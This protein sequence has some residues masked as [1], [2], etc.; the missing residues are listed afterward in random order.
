VLAIAARFIAIAAVVA[1]LAVPASARSVPNMANG[2]GFTFVSKKVVQGEDGH[3]SVR[4]RPSGSTC[5]LNVRYQG[6]TKQP[7]IGAAV[8][9]GGRA[10]WTWKVPSNVQAGPATA[11]VRCSRAGA[12]S[13]ALMIV[14]RLV[15]PKITV[16]KQ[17]FTTRPNPVIGTKL[18]YGVILHNGSPSK[19]AVNVSVQV[20]FV[21]GDNNLL[22]TDTQRIDGIAAGGDYALGRM[23]NFPAAA[24]ITRLE[25]VIQVE[26]YSAPSVHNPTLANM[27]LV[28]QIFDTRW[29]GTI[30]GEIQNTDAS[31][32]LQSANLSAVVFDAA[33]NVI[34]GG[35][36][37]AFQQL[38]P[39]A[40]QFIQLASGFDAIPIDRAASAMVSMSSTWKQPGS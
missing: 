38:P 9:T 37:F 20:N 10:A 3:V 24:P 36:G 13:H 5:T 19:D 16:V 40:R 7:G 25:V 26:K 29:L 2:V 12:T 14:G 11:T 8:A 32:I 21:M 33:G 18:S 34:G 39:G 6:G 30:E 35:S 31:L 1:V 17:G 4:V 23:V 28:P 22:G 15:E 27:H